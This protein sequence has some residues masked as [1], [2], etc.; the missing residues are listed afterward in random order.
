MVLYTDMA[1]LVLVNLDMKKQPK[2]VRIGMYW[3][4]D[5]DLLDI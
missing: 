5:L 2:V 3:V 4:L 1:A